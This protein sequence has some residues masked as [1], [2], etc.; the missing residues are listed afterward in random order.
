MAFQ[1]WVAYVRGGDCGHLSDVTTKEH[2]MCPMLWCRESFDSLASTLQHVSE[3]PWLSDAWYWCPYCRRPE[4][5]I[6]FE[7]LCKNPMPQNLQRKDSKLRRAVTFFKHLGLKN[8]SRHKALGSS[9]AHEAESFDTWLAKRQRLEMEDTSPTLSELANNSSDISDHVSYLERPAKKVYEMEDTMKDLDYTLQHSHEANPVIEP[10][11]LNTESLSTGPQLIGETASSATSYRGIGAQF[12]GPTHECELM[13]DMLVSPAST[14]GGSFD[15]RCTETVASPCAEIDSAYLACN[16]PDTVSLPEVVDCH[17]YQVDIAPLHGGPLPLLK[18]HDSPSDITLSTQLAVEDLRET[19][20]VLN[21]EWLR[22]C[23]STP[24][25]ILRISTLSPRYILDRGA[26]TLQLI[27]QGVLPRTFDA[28]FALAHIACAAAYIIHGDDSSH[29]WSDFFQDMLR[30]HDLIENG[31]DARLFVQLVNVLWRPQCSPAKRSCGNH[32]L[33]ETSGTLV[34]LR[35][36]EFSLD[37]LS[38]TEAVG[39]VDLDYPTMPASKMTLNSLKDGAI[40]QECSRFLDG[41]PA[42]HYSIIKNE[43]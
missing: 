31:S 35:R 27:F 24:D 28:A 40:L 29:C 43:Y 34:P 10:Y 17:Q 37:Q 42:H 14:V 15:H 18:H 5:F 6:A 22:R 23:Q 32:I 39:A 1:H 38:S 21:E 41:R 4:S 36:P 30:L 2:L 20:R 7:E 19:L 26:Q 33:D 11:E 9:A 3:C 13:A 25:Y 12:E 16:G 8:C